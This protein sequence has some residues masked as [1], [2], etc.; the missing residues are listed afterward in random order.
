MLLTKSHFYMTGLI[1]ISICRIVFNGQTA[2]AGD[3]AL[4][5]Y[6]KCNFHQSA[7]TVSLSDT[8]V[9]LNIRPKPVRAMRAL[10]FTLEISGRSLT[11]QPYIDLDMPAMAMGPNRVP[12]K[13]VGEGVYE[14]VGFIVKCPSG[15]K[16]WCAKVT[17]PGVGIA[18][19]VFHVLY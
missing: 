19:F 2:L 10:T 3:Q 13:P 1:L 5:I 14:G 8:T 6:K 15:L 16:V 12:M 9:T 18:E 4:R 7:C 17:L 11:S